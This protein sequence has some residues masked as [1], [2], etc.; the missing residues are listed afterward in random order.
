[1]ACGENPKR[2]YGSM[3]RMPDSRLGI[4]ALQRSQWYKAAVRIFLEF[5]SYLDI[6][7]TTRC[8]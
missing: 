3:G 8:I 7:T 1:M 2:V 4:G 5:S 6:K